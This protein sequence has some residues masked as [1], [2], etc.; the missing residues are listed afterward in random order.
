MSIRANPFVKLLEDPGLIQSEL[1]RRLEAARHV[2]P[3]KRRQDALQRDLARLQKS[4]E[5]CSPPTRKTFC[6]STSC[7]I[8][9]PICVSASTQ[10]APSCNRTQTRRPAGPLICVSPK[11]LTAFLARLRSSAEALDIIERQRVARLFVKEILVGDDRIIIRHSIPLP[12]GSS[13]G[14]DASPTGGSPAQT[15]AKVTFCVQGVISALLANIFLHYALDLRVDQW[16]R[17]HASGRVSIVRYADDFVMGFAK[18]ADARQ[19]MVDLKDRLAKFGLALHEDKTR[20][21]EFGRLPALRRRQRGERRPETFAFLGFTRDCRWTRDGRFIVKHKTQSKRLT[22][23]LTALR[24]EAWRHMHAPMAEQQRWYASILR[25]HYRYYGLPNNSRALSAFHQEVRRIWFRCLRQRSQ[26]AR[27]RTWDRFK[28][29]LERFLCHC[30]GSLILGRRRRHDAGYPREEPGAGKPHARICEGESRTAELP[31]HNATD[32][33]TLRRPR[34]PKEPV[35]RLGPET[36]MRRDFRGA[37]E[38]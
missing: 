16:R 17:R 10:S 7:A 15:W 35:P 38:T 24:Q 27:R 2:D 12:S 26:K 8:A 28:A 1:D 29:I 32:T 11:S 20:L 36:M 18:S 33:R 25:G 37:R 22:R 21:M 19:M 30:L 5:P 14:H 31:D 23:K 6:Q 3:T 13:G 9:C 4:I 34:F